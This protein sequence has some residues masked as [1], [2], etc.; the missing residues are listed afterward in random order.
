MSEVSDVKYVIEHGCFSPDIQGS[1]FELPEILKNKIT[2]FFVS[3]GIFF[4]V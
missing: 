4:L 2:L 1:F 3:I